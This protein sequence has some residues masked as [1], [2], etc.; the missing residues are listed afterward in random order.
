MNSD[1]IFGL[2]AILAGFF[3]ALQDTI[4]HHSETTWLRKIIRFDW[5]WTCE[6]K[7]INFG[8]I[9][10]KIDGWH[11]NKILSW[12][13]VAV[14]IGSVSKVTVVLGNAAF[15]YG[16]FWFLLCFVVFHVFYNVI[17]VSNKK[18]K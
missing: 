7:S 4:A 2:S 13:C 18:V 17:L 1:L 11:I 14:G 3:M 9:D 15:A 12:V 5:F 10:W 8:P 16:L 6:G